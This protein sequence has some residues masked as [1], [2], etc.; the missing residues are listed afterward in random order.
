MSFRICN[1]SGEDPNC[2]DSQLLDL[3]VFDHLHYLNYFET[4][5]D[6]VI[7]IPEVSLEITK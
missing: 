1:G 4:C 7:V 3:S 5:D 2:S 6:S